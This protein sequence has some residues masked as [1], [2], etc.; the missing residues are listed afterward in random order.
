MH[1]DNGEIAPIEQATPV[2]FGEAHSESSFFGE[3][4]SESSLVRPPLGSSRRYPAGFYPTFELQEDDDSTQTAYHSRVRI[5]DNAGEALVID[6]GA[7]R[8][9]SGSFWVDR[10]SHIAKLAGHGTAISALPQQVSIEEVGSGASKMTHKAEVPVALSATVTGLFKTGVI[11]DSPIPAL[12]GLEG[13][14]ANN[15]LL[16]PKRNRC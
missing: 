2:P 15:M 5:K 3:A 6:T 14:D 4:R 7:V 11:T 1:F 12:L 8:N 13:I 16:D 10:A 9:L